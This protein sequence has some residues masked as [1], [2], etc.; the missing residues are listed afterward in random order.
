MTKK[1][2][3]LSKRVILTKSFVNIFT[4]QVCAVSDATD[5]EILDEC[6]LGNPSGTS[7]GWSSVIRESDERLGRE[8]NNVPMPC[9]D[10]AGRIHFLVVC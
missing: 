10:H 8:K 9:D 5:K 7:G 3:D 6:N 2:I 4:M 1:E